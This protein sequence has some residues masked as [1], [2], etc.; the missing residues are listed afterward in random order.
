MV[1]SASNSGYMYAG[2]NLCFI[3]PNNV[4]KHNVI[5]VLGEHAIAGC[6]DGAA[7]GMNRR[8]AGEQCPREGRF[9]RTS[10]GVK[11]VF[12]SMK[13]YNAAFALRSLPFDNDLVAESKSGVSGLKPYRRKNRKPHT[14]EVLRYKFFSFGQSIA[15]LEIRVLLVFQLFHHV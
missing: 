3:A 13:I 14:F 4:R 5:R 6:G 11:S 15:N 9:E 10:K 7:H 2:H 12:L 8:H 1:A